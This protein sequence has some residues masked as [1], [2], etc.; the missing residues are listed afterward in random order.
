MDTERLTHTE[1]DI[2]IIALRLLE[3]QINNNHFDFSLEPEFG[4]DPHPPNWSDVMCLLARIEGT[5]GS[6][7]AFM[8]DGVLQ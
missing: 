3:D 2:I 8:S 4:N 7:H 1:R 5:R 6:N